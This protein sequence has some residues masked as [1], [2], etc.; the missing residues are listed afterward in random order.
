MIGRNKHVRKKALIVNKNK[1]FE[2]QLVKNKITDLEEIRRKDSIRQSIER[3]WIKCDKTFGSSRQRNN[4]SSLLL[5]TQ[6][7]FLT[8]VSDCFNKLRKTGAFVFTNQLE[9]FQGIDLMSCILNMSN[10][11]IVEYFPFVEG[12]LEYIQKTYDIPS[13]LFS[14]CSCLGRYMSNFIDILGGDIKASR[15]LT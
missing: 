3:G 7:R 1:V 15:P 13:F 5:N 6:F 8:A 14:Q 11:C 4:N 9:R 10:N 2:A 12:F